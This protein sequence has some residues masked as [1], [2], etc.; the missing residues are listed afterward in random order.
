[1]V[2]QA[3]GTGNIM[4][5]MRAALREVDPGVP[6]QALQTMDRSM[7]ETIAE[8]VFQM[9]VLATFA[10]LA[11]LLA[12]LGMY[13]VLAYDV[14]ARTRE[15]GLRMA[16]GATPGTVLRM[17]LGRTVVLA[18]LGGGIGIA[19]ALALTR[20]LSHSLFEVRPDDPATLV[21]VWLVLLVAALAAGYL[22]AR[23]ATRIQPQTALQDA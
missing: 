11:L 13:G 22:P 15:I 5:A 1:V 20:L 16:L 23:R 21:A 10:L 4:T 8:P 3:P 19:G 14:T 2:R 6:A 17:V 7:M 12:V 18:L 9:R